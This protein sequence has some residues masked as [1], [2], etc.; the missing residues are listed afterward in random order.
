VQLPPGT[1]FGLH[2]G[3]KYTD[4]VTFDPAPSDVPVFVRAGA[5]VP[6]QAIVQHT[7]ETPQGPLSVHV[8]WPDAGDDCSGAL[9]DDDGHSMAYRKGAYLR[10][11]FACEVRDGGMTVRATSEHA[12]FAPWWTSVEVVV[13][14]ADGGAQV[15]RIDGAKTDWEVSLR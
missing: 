4:K 3:N 12:Q 7:G 10:I 14:R 5:I 11:R 8:W 13:H 9:Y 15:E 1:W 2:D 6:M